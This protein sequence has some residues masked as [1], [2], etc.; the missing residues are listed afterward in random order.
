MSRAESS[1][2]EVL[3]DDEPDLEENPQTDDLEEYPTRS[4]EVKMII[5]RTSSGI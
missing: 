2:D 5:T 3:T 4:Q 1:L